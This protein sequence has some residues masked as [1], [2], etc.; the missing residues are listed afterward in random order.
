M[1]ALR[2]RGDG[3]TAP[4]RTLAWVTAVGLLLVIVMGSLVTDT[5]SGRGCGGTWPLCNGRFVPELAVSSLIE[6]SHRAVAS[7]VGLMT[8][9]L[10]VWSWRAVRRP[11][12]RALAAVGLG[13]VVVQGL[14]GAADVLWPEAPSV[15]A[16]HYG[17]SLI[18]FA[19]VLLLALALGRPPAGPA[20]PLPR[21]FARLAWA[22]TAYVYGLVYLGAYVAHSHAAGACGDWPLCRGQLVPADLHGPVAVEFAHRLAALGGVGLCLWLFLAARPLRRRRRDAYQA[23]HV[24]LAA[25]VLQ[26]LSGAWVVRGGAGLWPVLVHGSLVAA[27][28]GALAYLALA[29]VPQAEALG[30]AAR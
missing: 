28:F 29:G 10:A 19:G 27:L 12:V 6:Y 23:A 14:L 11:A 15:L 25:V 17:F 2:G 30:A 13:F 4:L 8:V 26:A 16:L 24:A 3:A 1:S 21:P 22:T 7:V 9:V 18:A 5:G 20:A